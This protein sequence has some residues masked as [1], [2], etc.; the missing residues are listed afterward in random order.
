MHQYFRIYCHISQTRSRWVKGNWHVS[1][2]MSITNFNGNESL[3]ICKICSNI[4]G[5]QYMYGY[6]GTR[7]LFTLDTIFF[8]YGY[9]FSLDVSIKMLDYWSSKLRNKFQSNRKRNSYISI[10]GNA[11]EY[12]V[13]EMANFLSWQL[14]EPMV[15]SL[16]THIC[17]TRPHWFYKQAG[18]ISYDLYCATLPITLPE[19]FDLGLLLC[20]AATLRLIIPALTSST[21]RCRSSLRHDLYRFFS[22]QAFS[23][24]YV[25]TMATRQIKNHAKPC[26]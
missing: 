13:C 11:L 23:E 15:L 12:V 3:I 26:F 1:R 6:P 16:L 14:S 21:A 19:M 22:L 7:I 20:P 24:S 18:S 5:V 8:R 25:W 9:I 10:Q 2:F 4:R 17:V